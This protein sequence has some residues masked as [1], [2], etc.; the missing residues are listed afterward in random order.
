MRS[1]AMLTVQFDGDVLGVR[2]EG[3]IT[4][5][6]VVVG[7]RRSFRT[8]GVDHLEEVRATNW[9]NG[10]YAAVQA[11]GARTAKERSPHE[12]NE[13]PGRTLCRAQV[14]ANVRFLNHP[15]RPTYGEVG[16]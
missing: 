10:V 3:P 14:A 6:D 5:E 1:G 2:P 13:P 16:S 7:T 4:R 12:R 15:D 9:G 11:N 8:S